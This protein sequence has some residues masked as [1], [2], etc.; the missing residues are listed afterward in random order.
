MDSSLLLFLLIVFIIGAVF[1]VLIGKNRNREFRKA[2][3]IKFFSYLLILLSLVLPQF[4]FPLLFTVIASAIVFVGFFEIVYHLSKDHRFKERPLIFS[5]SLILYLITAILFVQFSLLQEGVILYII[6][7]IFSFD[8][9]C[10]LWGQLVGKTKLF[11]KVSP[12]K[13]VEGLIGGA[14]SAAIIAWLLHT[15]YAL[16]GQ[17]PVLSFFVIICGALTGDLL[18]SKLK[19]MLHLKDYSNLLPGQGGFLDRFDSLLVAG[20]LIF[21]IHI[22]IL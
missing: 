14:I 18:A 4:Y 7:V 22:F 10:Q 1:L 13:T 2:N 19:R 5:F 11:P 16:N 8:A 3:W 17:L 15:F 21:L 12:N 9:F 20:A 6:L